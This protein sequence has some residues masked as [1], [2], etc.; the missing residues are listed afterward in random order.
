MSKL[1]CSGCLSSVIILALVMIILVMIFQ[2]QLFRYKSR[3]TLTVEQRIELK[4]LAGEALK[5]KDVPIGAILVYNDRIIG[6]GFNTVI[7]DGN[8]AGH[9]EINAI[10][11]AITRIGLEEFQE[12]DRSELIVIST[13]EPCEMCK[14]TFDHYRIRKIL[15][16]KEKSWTERIKSLFTSLRSSINKRQSEGETLQDSLFNL[17]P[18]YPGRKH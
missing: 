2:D 11:D 6:K 14:G 17:H 8:V 15:F 1:G 18:D 7:R 16:L 9:A 4:K 10:N 5:S 12:L 13:Y 3:T